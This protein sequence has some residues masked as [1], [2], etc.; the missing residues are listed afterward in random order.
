[1]GRLLKIGFTSATI[2]LQGVTTTYRMI[3]RLFGQKTVT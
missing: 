2:L 3:F 1:M